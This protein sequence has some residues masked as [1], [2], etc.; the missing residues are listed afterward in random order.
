MPSAQCAYSDAIYESVQSMTKWVLDEKTGLL[1][2]KKESIAKA[3]EKFNKT[4]DKEGS[5]AIVEAF[6]DFFKTL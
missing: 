2:E 6:K 1:I 5:K 3:A 4:V